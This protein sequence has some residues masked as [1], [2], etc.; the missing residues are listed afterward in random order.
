MQTAHDNLYK[1]AASIQTLEV[2]LQADI[3][4]MNVA[5]DGLQAQ[6]WENQALC[7]AAIAVG[8]RI[9][10]LIVRIAVTWRPP[11]LGPW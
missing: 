1:G 5:M 11:A 7:A 9:F 6:I 10:I 2:S 8:L 4:K 3:G